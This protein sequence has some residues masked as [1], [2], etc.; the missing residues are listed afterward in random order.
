MEQLF[1]DLQKHIATRMGDSIALI[2]E[3]YGQLEALAGGEEQYP[4]TFPCILIGTPEVQWDNLK[5]N[6][7]HG[8]C[9]LT[10]RLAF[11]CYDDTHYGST[12]EH[13]ATERMRLA[14]RLNDCLHGWSFEGCTTVLIRRA[15]RQFSLPGGIKVYETEYYTTVE[16][17]IQNN[18]S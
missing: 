13:H 7:Q 17:G 11:D 6:R 18:D 16:D 15:S 2:D 9:S 10:T 3:D 1:N 8:R 12:Q 5:G 14:S 4:V